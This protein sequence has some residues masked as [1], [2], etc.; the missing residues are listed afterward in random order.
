M[1]KSSP[2]NIKASLEGITK[3]SPQTTDDSNKKKR[4]LNVSHEK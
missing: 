4:G 2:S 1:E 3:R